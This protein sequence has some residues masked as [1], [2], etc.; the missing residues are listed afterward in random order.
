MWNRTSRSQSAIVFT[1]VKKDQASWVWFL[2]AGTSGTP[3]FEHV[4][5]VRFSSWH[6]LRSEDGLHNSPCLFCSNRDMVFISTVLQIAII[7]EHYSIFLFS[8]FTETLTP[9]PDWFSLFF[10]IGN[11]TAIMSNVIMWMHQYMEYLK[12][13]NK[14]NCYWFSIIDRWIIAEILLMGNALLQN[15]RIH[16]I[17]LFFF[18]Y[19]QQLSL[20]AR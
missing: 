19:Q 14:K 9:I 5:V 12:I 13:F 6:F 10:G 15:F 16:I 2:R 17:I 20:N 8:E 3:V 11:G 1:T 18:S 4:P 7:P